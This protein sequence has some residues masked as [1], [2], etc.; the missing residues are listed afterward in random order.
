MSLKDF[1]LLSKLGD[2]AFSIVHKARRL[3]DNKIYA[4]KRVKMTK[5]SEAEK[6]NAINEVRILASLDHPNII[7]YKEAF[8]DDPSSTLC[9]VM[10]FASGGDLLGKVEKLKARGARFSEKDLWSYLIQSLRGLEY[11]HNSSI[12]HRD[13]KC[14]NMFLSAE[15]VIKLGDMNVSK[16]Q[17]SGLMRTQTGTP[18]YAP[19]EIWQDKP[20]NSKCDI[21]SLGCVLYEFAALHPPFRANSMKD[22][23][24]RVVRGVYPALPKTYS[25]QFHDVIKQMLVVNQSS[26]PSASEMLNSDLLKKQFTETI[27]H[28]G[29]DHKPQGCGLLGTIQL[30]RN[31]RQINGRLPAANYAEKKGLR[32][33]NSEPGRLPSIERQA[34]LEKKENMPQIKEIVEKKRGLSRDGKRDISSSRLARAGMYALPSNRVKPVD[35]YSRNKEYIQQSQDA[36]YQRNRSYD[37]QIER[38][39]YGVPNPPSRQNSRR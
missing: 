8:F 4:L 36:R 31:L 35:I 9:I 18:Y 30:P 24:A 28:L 12:C 25:K 26:R 3:S 1:Q 15:G 34:L 17:K 2:G 33:M 14:A 6:V 32:R 16:V 22:L 19:P 27:H 11:L 21:W 10:E 13:L 37:V 7:A 20:Y 39:Q 5:L 29:I 38:R 23:A